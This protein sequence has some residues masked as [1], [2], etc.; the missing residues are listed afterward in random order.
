MPGTSPHSP[1][2]AENN[3][4]KKNPPTL[5]LPSQPPA[6]GTGVGCNWNEAIGIHDELLVRGGDAVLD[7]KPW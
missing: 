1:I 7:L 4:K 6:E 2:K 3:Q 5:C